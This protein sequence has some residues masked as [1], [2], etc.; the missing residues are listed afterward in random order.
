M[1]GGYHA[2]RDMVL[3]LDTA[4]FKY[5]PHW[6]VPRPLCELRGSCRQ[7]EMEHPHPREGR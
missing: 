4:R 6:C 2:E 5:P 7:L 1:T 3:I